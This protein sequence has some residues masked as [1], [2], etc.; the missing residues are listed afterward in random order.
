MARTTGA[1]KKYMWEILVPAYDANGE[2]PLPRHKQWDNKVNVI[3]GGLTIMKPAVGHWVSPAGK[4]FR[5]KMI[6]VRIACTRLQIDAI[7]H[8]SLEHYGG[9]QVIL[10]YRV[11]DTVL[12]FERNGH[13][14]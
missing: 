4:L 9:E 13:G 6:P 2:I 12:M 5:D 8:M 14:K 1:M 11:S 10:V 7:G 3:A